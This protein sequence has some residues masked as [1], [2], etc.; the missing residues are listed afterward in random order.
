MVNISILVY[1][2]SFGAA[3]FPALQ[4]LNLTNN[5]MLETFGKKVFKIQLVGY[6]NRHIHLGTYATIHCDYTTK[7]NFHQDLIILPGYD[8]N[9]MQECDCNNFIPLKEWLI[10]EH[11]KGVEIGSMCTGALLLAHSGLLDNHACT[12]HWMGCDMIK[13]QFPKVE[14]TPSKIITQNNG[15]YTAGGG[16]SSMQ[17]IF[18]F[19]EKYCSREVATLISKMVAFEYPLKS[20]N[21]FYIF[22]KQKNHGDEEI[23]MAQNYMEKQYEEQIKM[24]DLSKKSNMSTRNFI[25]RFKKAT[26]DTPIEYLQRVRIEVAK[27]IFEDGNPS[28]SDVMYSIGYQDIK[29]FGMLF[30]RMTGMTPSAYS[31]RFKEVGV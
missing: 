19:I 2:N 26:G 16:M 18:F 11:Q 29:S 21:Q 13:S 5:Y 25:R 12:T 9:Q 28:V 22:N 31:K 10:R 1:E 3:I 24:D 6:Q 7:D 30:K 8:I 14:M 15:I 17:L 4:V 27:K 23:K 20:Q